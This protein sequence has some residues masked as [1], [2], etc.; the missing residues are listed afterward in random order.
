MSAPSTRLA[1]VIPCYNAGARLRPVAE[2]ALRQVDRVIVVDDGCND[3]CIGQLDGM[4]V[5]IERHAQNLGKGHAI[6]TGIRAALEDP[7]MEAVVLLDADGQHD[8]AAIPAFARRFQESGAG[9]VIG[10]RVFDGVEVP[11][12]SR[13]GNTVTAAVTRLLL[14]E[15]L[16]DTQCGFRLFSRAF[17]E[18]VLSRVRGG[19]YETEMEMV[20][21]AV[22]GKAGLASVPIKTVYEPGNASSHF[23]KVSDSAR[24]YARLLRAVARHAG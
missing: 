12:R 16:P 5:Q 23:R 14:G 17:A 18:Q 4:P 15:R 22:R 1:C 2:S 9:M 6:L 20:V 3:G 7:A 11:W 19:R 10:A 13:F 24:I 21:M 8:P